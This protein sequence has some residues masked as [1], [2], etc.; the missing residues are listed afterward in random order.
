M[1]DLKAPVYGSQ[2]ASLLEQYHVRLNANMNYLLVHSTIHNIHFWF[3]TQ[4]VF[5]SLTQILHKIV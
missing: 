2:G 1:I 5:L 3:A 4:L